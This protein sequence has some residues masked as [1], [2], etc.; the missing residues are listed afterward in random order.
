MWPIH[1]GLHV[2]LAASVG[3]ERV[4]VV[5]L[6]SD[7][8]D[9]VR[10]WWATS[11][12]S[13]AE[14]VHSGE[15]L[16]PVAAQLLD[17]EREQVPELARR[18]DVEDPVG[19]RGGVVDA[20]AQLDPPGRVARGLGT[21]RGERQ[22]LAGV[23][24]EVDE[25]VH[26]GRRRTDRPGPRRG[27][28]VADPREGQV[29]DIVGT[30]EMLAP[31]EPLMGR[32]RCGTGSSSTLSAATRW[33]GVTARDA[34]PTA[35]SVAETRAAPSKNLARTAMM[36]LRTP[37]GTGTTQT[38][39]AGRGW[40]DTSRPEGPAHDHPGRGAAHDLTEP[41][42]LVEAPRAEEHEVVVAS[43]GLVDRVCLEQANPVVPGEVDRRS[44]AACAGRRG[45]DAPCRRTCTRSTRPRRRRRASSPAS[46]GASGSPRAGRG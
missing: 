4:D 38:R 14:A 2:R 42:P 39:S 40:F 1:R 11:R 29:P 10:D 23:G 21:V 6:R 13:P 7:V 17:V 19:D 20:F 28:A 37:V 27:R 35:T 26:D 32:G 18:A 44:R 45:H 34:P 9:T 22:Q 41:G 25:P 24:A 31:V 8:H 12:R 3:G 46:G 33:S 15:Q 30:D 43:L 36:F 16:P 5:E